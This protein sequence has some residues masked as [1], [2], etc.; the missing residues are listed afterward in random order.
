MCIRDRYPIIIAIE[1]ARVSLG[2][3]QDQRIGQRLKPLWYPRLQRLS[4]LRIVVVHKGNRFQGIVLRQRIIENRPH[5]KCSVAGRSI[6]KPEM[7]RHVK[8]GHRALRRIDIIFQR[9]QIAVPILADRK[10][11]PVFFI[12]QGIQ[13]IAVKGRCV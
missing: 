8:K 5:I 3:Q 11:L 10:Q 7:E 12:A 2:A 1:N 4:R 6:K 13:P 9:G